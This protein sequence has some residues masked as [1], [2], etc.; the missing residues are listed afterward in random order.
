MFQSKGK[1]EEITLVNTNPCDVRV[2]RSYTD[3][4]NSFNMF[5]FS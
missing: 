2:N 4:M 1:I 3:Q 5:D